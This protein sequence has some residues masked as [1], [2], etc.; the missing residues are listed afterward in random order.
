[1]RH[2]GRNIALVIVVLLIAGLSIFPPEEKLRLGK[3][4]AGGVSLTY[5]VDVPEGED[6]DLLIPRVIQVLTERINPS[7]LFEISFVRQG[8]DRL[9]V[10]M[11]LPSEAVQ[12]LRDE[13]EAALEAVGDHDFDVAQFE[14][15][16]RLRG[17]ART[18]ALDAMMDTPGREALLGPVRDAA[19]AVDR[20][21]AAYDTAVAVEEA[22]GTAPDSLD[23]LLAAAADAE[24]A[25]DDVRSVALVNRVSPED[26]REALN[27][28]KDGARIEGEDGVFVELP[29][30]RDTAL[31]TL[32]QQLE[33]SGGKGAFDAVLAAEAVYRGERKS[34]DD[35][36]DLERRM[37]SSG[38]L[39][40]RIVSNSIEAGTNEQ[41]LRERLLERGPSSVN[42]PGLMWAPLNKLSDWADS[43]DDLNA[44]EAD[45]VG[46]FRSQRGLIVQLRP[47]DGLYYVLLSDAPGMRLTAQEGEWSLSR[48]F[49]TTDQLGRPAIG[50]EMDPRGATRLGDL[51]GNN[52]GRQMAVLLDGKVYT[53]PNLIG[54][55]SNNGQIT[56]S[57]TSSEIEYIVK[58]LNA[59]SLQASLS[60]RP[61]SKSILAPE[62]GKDNLT[63]G[64]T[65][66]LI[67]LALVGVFMVLYYFVSGFV[68]MFALICNAVIILGAMSL[69]QA[70]FT[71]P[72]IA[73]IVLTFGMAVD[74]N[75]LIYERIREELLRGEDVK[76]AVRV[77][78]QKVLSTIVDANVTNL[79]VCFVLAYTAS[80][81]IKGFAITL[82]IGVVATMFSALLITRIIFTLLID[83]VKIKSLAQLPTAVP[84]I[85]RVLTP[86]INWIGLRPLFVVVSLAL[87][88]TGIGFMYMQQDELLD[89]EFRGGTQVDLTLKTLPDGSR[90]TITR[91]EA[92]E[93]V[94]QIY[95]AAQQVLGDPESSTEEQLR[96]AEWLVTLQNADVVMINPEADGITSSQVQIKSSASSDDPNARVDRVL[97]TAI[98]DVFQDVVDA[99]PALAFSGSDATEWSSA[100]VFPILD[101]E[102]GASIQEPEITNDVRPYIGGVAIILDGL[103]PAP[104]L[105]SL[106]DRLTYVRRQASFA[107][108]ALRR[109]FDIIVLE[110]SNDAVQR[111]AIVVHDSDIDPILDQGRWQSE[112]AQGEWTITREAIA[113]AQTLA[114][115]ESFSPEIAATFRN[116]AIVAVALSFLLITMYIWARFGSVRYSLAA[117]SCLVH[118]VII[119]IGLIALAEILYKNF[120]ALAAIGIQ[121]FKIDLG[122]VAAILTIIGYSLNDTII[123]LDRIRENRGK[124]AYASKDVVNLSINQTISRTLITSG[125]TL[126]ALLVMFIIGGEGIASF[127]YALLCGVLI[128]TYSS[129][130]VA[131]PL[132]YTAKIPEQAAQFQ[133]RYGAKAEPQADPTP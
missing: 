81:E 21:R 42:V 121:P 111:A 71:L 120:P 27:R 70:S 31:E 1:M 85:D 38:V 43:T 116:Q 112:L 118:D 6:P 65:A 89:T 132:V 24:V 75:V 53:A 62:L 50:F 28:S 104:T 128:G 107:S 61:I 20:T 14:R 68:A 93:R 44:I 55:I 7:G 122:L 35:P 83:K 77:A 82:G 33:A 2:L 117:L 102:L 94:D 29:S 133:Q 60:E 40:F 131:A 114:G 79:I 103:T 52:L 49:R 109:S 32:Q 26:M 25:L 45:H 72:G 73:G 10:S 57:F 97:Q 115:V 96:E 78:Y 90:A 54:R 23:D 92:Q 87:M 74:A 8:R 22:G 16:M 80:Q 4:L 41:E 106:E 110:G 47:E 123:I 11:P 95:A 100:P 108:E 125:T 99:Q 19:Q 18:N 129:I 119:A 124:L 30:P 48:S 64:L 69:N 63:K 59:G 51:T 56:G 5:T 130:A 58:T 17:E 37:A 84:V 105:E 101:A 34:L 67:A 98:V 66:S 76:A 9:V 12:Q 91:A 127:T 86:K 15:A 3:D 46:Y 39:E 88:G 13:F 36:D 126:I 113:R